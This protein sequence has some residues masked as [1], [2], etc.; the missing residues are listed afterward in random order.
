MI[1]A[2]EHGFVEGGSLK[3]AEMIVMMVVDAGH[4]G[5]PQS[6]KS[7]NSRITKIVDIGSH[8]TTISTTGRTEGVVAKQRA[9]SQWM[10]LPPLPLTVL[11]NDWKPHGCRPQ[12][13]SALEHSAHQSSTV[14]NMDIDRTMIYTA[15]TPILAL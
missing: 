13:L 8:P 9:W 2:G 6:T 14:K 5:Y 11:L 7:N 12:T 1:G 4:T 10:F 15:R 3:V